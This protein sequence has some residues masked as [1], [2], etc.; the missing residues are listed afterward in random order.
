[1]TTIPGQR[2]A[3]L[4]PAL[5]IVTLGVGDLARAIAFYEALGWRRAAAS[6][7]SAIAWFDAGTLALGLFPWEQLAADAGLVA[8]PAPTEPRFSGV[9]LAI[10][11]ESEQAVDAG[12][13]AI[14]DAGGSVVKPAVKAEWG[15]YSGYGADP[16]GHLWEV[17][18]NP[19]FP[20]VDGIARVP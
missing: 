3:S 16:D 14:A 19:M 15:G 5:A 1:M 9:T 4:P 12:L 18:Y 20:L 7:E 6:V 2:P 8:G 17:A 11:V 13:K 10:N